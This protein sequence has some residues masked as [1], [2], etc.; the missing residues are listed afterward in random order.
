M[1]CCKPFIT[2]KAY[3][4]TAEQL[5]RSRYTAYTRA[6]VNYIADTMTGKAAEGFNKVDA[7]Q[8]ALA[9]KW[10]GL[11]VIR[12]E[13]GGENDETG[14]VEFIATYKLNAKRETISETSI[15][16]KMAGKWLYVGGE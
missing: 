9:A 16:Q 2:G 4:K 7:K 6:N 1:K 3:P 15:F 13:A 12:S 5:M 14:L 8:W 10:L 11:K